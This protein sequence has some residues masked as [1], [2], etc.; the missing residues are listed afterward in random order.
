[1]TF[2]APD[3]LQKIRSLIRDCGLQ[4]KHMSTEQFQVFEKGKDDY[5]TPIDR[6]L[7]QRL[8]AGF[9]ELFPQDG[10][11]TEENAQSGKFRSALVN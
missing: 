10:V 3:Q 5:V 9:A 1:M 2:F 7:D 4:A 11:I 8:T 6:A